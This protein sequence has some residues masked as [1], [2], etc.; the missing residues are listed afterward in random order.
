MKTG[1]DDRHK[2]LR[3]KKNDIVYLRLHHSYK[4][5]SHTHRKYSN[6]RIRVNIKKRISDAAYKLELPEVMKIHPVVSIIQLEAAPP[7]PNPYSREPY[8]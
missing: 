8:P 7:D 4:I 6:Q 3:F 5:P 2:P 1:Y